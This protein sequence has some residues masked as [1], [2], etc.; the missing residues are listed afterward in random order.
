MWKWKT[1]CQA[2]GSDELSKLIPSHPS[3][4]RM[5]SASRFAPAATRERSSGSISS[6]LRECVRGITSAWP[7]VHGL[8]SMNDTVCSSW[9]TISAGSS[10]VAILQK[11]QS[12]A[13]RRFIP[14][15]ASCP[16]PD[17]DGTSVSR[18]SK[19]AD[20]FEVPPEA[21]ADQGHDQQ[22]ARVPEVPAELRHVVEVHPVDPGDHRRHRDDRDPGRYPAHVLVLAHGNL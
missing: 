22:H 20:P 18:L 9:S 12:S 15:R 8:M 13:T 4:S 2:A 6:R 21:E 7:R 19:P 17:A 10:P 1:V 14:P 3:R 5:R 11:M 16:R